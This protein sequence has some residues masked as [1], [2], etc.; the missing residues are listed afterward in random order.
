MI[1]ENTVCL[2]VFKVIPTNMLDEF[3]M[4]EVVESTGVTC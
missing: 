4:G 2:I 1:H 3:A